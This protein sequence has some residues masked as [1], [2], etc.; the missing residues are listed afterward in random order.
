[1]HLIMKDYVRN[2]FI[3]LKLFIMKKKTELSLFIFLWSLLF[4]LFFYN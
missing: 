1:M 2:F 4:P 3:E